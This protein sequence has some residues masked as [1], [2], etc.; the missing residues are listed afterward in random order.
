MLNAL[1]EDAMDVD[2]D[3]EE[4]GVEEVLLSSS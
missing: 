1:R 4:R 3:L 2:R